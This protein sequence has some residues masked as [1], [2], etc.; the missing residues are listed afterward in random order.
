[1][2]RN[3]LAPNSSSKDVCFYRTAV[4]GSTTSSWRS[5]ESRCWDAPTTPPWRRCGGPCH[6]R[7]TSEEPSSWWCWG[8]PRF[9]SG[10][11]RGERRLWADGSVP[12]QT[13][14]EIR[15]VQGSREPQPHLSLSASASKYWD[16]QEISESSVN[17]REKMLMFLSTGVLQVT[18]RIEHFYNTYLEVDTYIYIICM[19]SCIYVDMTQ[20]WLRL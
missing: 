1:M 15:L 8:S 6:R 13:W 18:G 4:W 12:S 10:T 16:P 17:R 5:T 19:C 11:P 3:L 14:R 7:G 2:K 9:V 20:L